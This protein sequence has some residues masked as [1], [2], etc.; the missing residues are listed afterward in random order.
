MIKKM[1][2]REFLENCD[3]SSWELGIYKESTSPIP[4]FKIKKYDIEDFLNHQNVKYN[5]NTHIVE[6][7]EQVEILDWEKNIEFYIVYQLD[8]STRSFT[9]HSKCFFNLKDAQ[10]YIIFCVIN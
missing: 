10:D 4:K 7:V 6:F 9:A 5:S 8:Y 2:W 1:T 3:F